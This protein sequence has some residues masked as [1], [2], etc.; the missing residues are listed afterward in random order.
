MRAL[1]GLLLLVALV[2]GGWAFNEA[3]KEVKYLCFNFAAGVPTDRVLSQLG[4]GEF[5][6]YSLYGAPQ[7]S[8]IVVDSLYTL[9]LH[10]C[11]IELDA[12]GEVI[13]ASAGFAVPF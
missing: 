13:T 2:G 11:V 8:R 5:L 3:R 9:T 7:G 10:R 12:R 1:L 4:T 6:R